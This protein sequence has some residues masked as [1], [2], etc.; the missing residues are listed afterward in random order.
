[1]YKTPPIILTILHVFLLLSLEQ[2]R[3]G[4]HIF[5]LRL[6]LIMM[7]MNIKLNDVTFRTLKYKYK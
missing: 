4:G 2:Y 3:R 5:I 1:M 7:I 6:I